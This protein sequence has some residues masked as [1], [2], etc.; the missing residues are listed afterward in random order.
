[1]AFDGMVV[2]NLSS[3]MK[4]QLTG[5]RIT[6]IAQPEK[7]ALLFTIKQRTK[8]E[9]QGKTIR[10][11]KRLWISVNASLPLMYLMDE[12]KPSPM[13]APN[14]CMVLRKHLNN[15]RILDVY[16]YQFERVI[17][18]ELEHLNEMGDLCKKTLYI[19]LMGKHSNIIF[20]D[21]DGTIIDS[22]K[23][24]SALVSSVREV[25]PGKTYFIPNT[26]DKHNPLTITEEELRLALRQKNLP[27]FKAIYMVLT[28]FSPVMA[29]EL[30]FCAGID[31]D[32]YTESLTD[33]MITHLYRNLLTFMS[34]VNCGTFS[35]VILYEGD[36]PKEFSAIPLTSFTKTNPQCH[37]KTFS[38]ISQVLYTYY[39]EKEIY[40]RIHQKSAELR[41]IVS[42]M[43]ERN[44]KKYDLQLRQ[45]KDT[46]KRDKYKIYGEL[47]TTYGYE[48]K[49]GDKSLT[50][51]NYYNGEEI[52]IPLEETE[53]A[54][55]NAKRFFAK[56]NKLKRTS[57]A[58][59]VQIAET[60]ENIEHLESVQTAL[61]IAR[62]EAD[63]SA[64]RDEL[65]ETGYIRRLSSGKKKA[66][67]PLKSKPLHYISSDGFHM[68][69]GKNNY[70]NDELTFHFATGNDWWFHAKKTAGSHVI[71]KTGGEE[72]P[73]RTF[74]E[75]GKLAAFYSKN[76]EASKVE[77]DYIEKKHVKKPNGAKP[78]FVVYYTNYSLMA[79]PDISG[80]KEVT[81][82]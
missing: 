4:K 81:D 30:C 18:M 28:G 1:M 75:A 22:I 72:L 20:V 51:I 80:I 11:Q 12:N 60:K 61:A 49:P 36:E 52:T 82:E 46:E 77:I 23:H 78:G 2:A 8:D 29:N 70:Q 71:V 57:E 7:D 24:V 35:P 19:E 65:V 74:E 6:K 33:G 56:Y 27:V 25:L 16:Q 67:S 58:L 10:E 39:A 38:S 50:C 62:T 69:V 17:A 26:L 44:L 13:T 34:P 53:S 14:F 47:L 59:A 64:I 31:S 41:K 5:A 37:S 48:A 3:D 43:L 55:D 9:E 15:C 32:T 66:K 76:R 73:D 68:Y 63:L 40:S 79:E 42:T 45:M 21:S 54:M